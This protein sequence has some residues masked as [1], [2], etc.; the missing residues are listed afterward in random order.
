M[1]LVRM[2][3]NG[4]ISIMVLQQHFALHNLSAKMDL[5][6]TFIKHH[7]QE[8]GLCI[9]S[10]LNRNMSMVDSCWQLACWGSLILCS[11]RIYISISSQLMM[12]PLLAFYSVE[13]PLKL[14]QWMITIPEL[15]A[16]T[17]HIS[18]LLL[19][20]LILVFQSRVQQLSV[21]DFYTRVLVID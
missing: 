16:F 17:F 2:F 13:P 15:S 18:Y 4:Q 7:I 1:S 20:V 21:L 11:Q 3:F 12:L 9:T 8:I 19:L 5:R 6:V 14:E 10:L